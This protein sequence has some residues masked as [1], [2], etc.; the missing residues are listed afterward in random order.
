MGGLGELGAAEGCPWRGGLGVSKV[1]FWWLLGE[2]LRCRVLVNL[3]GLGLGRCTSHNACDCRA[4]GPQ[5]RSSLEKLDG[6]SIRWRTVCSR[7]LLS[8]RTLWHHIA[9][10][11]S[12]IFVVELFRLIST[13]SPRGRC[14]WSTTSSGKGP[15]GGHAEPRCG[16]SRNV[17]SM[18]LDPYKSGSASWVR[19]HVS[20]DL[21]SC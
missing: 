20:H 14:T 11:Y 18:S 21:H 6:Y 19:I 17:F 2:K 7:G 8:S 3:A 5:V 10:R 4:Q 16:S 15:R 13:A 1:V 9:R 12:H